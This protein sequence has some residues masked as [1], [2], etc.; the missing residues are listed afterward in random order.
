MEAETQPVKLVVCDLSTS[1][2]IDVSG[3]RLLAQLEDDLY[4]QG[5][6]FRV[7]EAHAEVR[8]MLR[9]TAIS[10]RLG[11]VSRRIALA[12]IVENYELT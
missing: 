9:A 4:K 6:D 1:P 3:A 11:G 10:E 8:E 5:I 12:D 2:Y 7:A